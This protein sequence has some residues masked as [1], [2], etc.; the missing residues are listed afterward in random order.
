MVSY[1]YK[2]WKEKIVEQYKTLQ[3]ASAQF[4]GKDIIAHTTVAE[5]VTVTEY[6]NG[7]MIVNYSDEAYTHEGVEIPAKQYK[8]IPGGTK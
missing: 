7:K 5:D 1:S 8:V 4:A 6:E 2:R 3:E